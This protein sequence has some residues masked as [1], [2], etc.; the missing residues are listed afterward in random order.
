MASPVLTFEG[1]SCLYYLIP[2][3]HLGTERKN[4][5]DFHYGYSYLSLQISRQIK[6]SQLVLCVNTGGAHDPTCDLVVGYRHISNREHMILPS[7]LDWER[8]NKE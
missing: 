8:S 7:L 5:S 4:V 1:W 2:N 3:I 6:S